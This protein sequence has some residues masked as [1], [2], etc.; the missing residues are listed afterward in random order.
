MMI[1]DP[2]GGEPIEW[3]VCF[4]RRAATPWLERLPIGEFKHV[5]AFGCVPSINTWVF[6]D[7]AL[8]RTSIKVARGPAATALMHEWLID[9]EVVRMRSSHRTTNIPRLGAW[10]VPAI[11]HIVGIRSGA[12]L[13]DGL[14]RYCM[15]TGGQ[16]IESNNAPEGEKS[17]PSAT[18]AAS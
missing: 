8:N 7:P 6:F 16:L 2:G 14:H 17:S 10:C 3:F 9:S 18:A 1:F 11:K 5:R 15:D 12:L 13:P 4:C